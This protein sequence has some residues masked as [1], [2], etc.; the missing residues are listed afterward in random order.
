MVNN[1]P[2]ICCWNHCISKSF[3]HWD[4]LHHWLKNVV[5]SFLPRFLCPNSYI[6]ASMNELQ[7]FHLSVLLSKLRQELVPIFQYLQN[8]KP[9]DFSV[10]MYTYV[11]ASTSLEVVKFYLYVR[12]HVQTNLSSK[13]ST[14]LKISNSAWIHRTFYNVFIAWLSSNVIPAKTLNKFS[15]ASRQEGFKHIFW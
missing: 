1:L 15:K 10:C 7:S 14:T 12:Y 8:L 13:E 4:F 5:S 9:D 6:M 2:L 3:I 11:C